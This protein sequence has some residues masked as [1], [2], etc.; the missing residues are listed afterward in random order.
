MNPTISDKEYPVVETLMKPDSLFEKRLERESREN[1]ELY[2]KINDEIQLYFKKKNEFRT[3][4]KWRMFILF[5]LNAFILIIARDLP[6]ILHQEQRM[7][8]K[9]RSAKEDPPSYYSII[10]Y[11]LIYWVPNMFLPLIFGFICDYAANDMISLKLLL[12]TMLVPVLLSQI[13]LIIKA[14]YESIIVSRFLF[15]FTG[16]TAFVMLISSLEVWF[17]KINQIS[18]ICYYIIC[19]SF[20]CGLSYLFLGILSEY[21]KGNNNDEDNFI[22]VESY[23]F[24]FLIVLLLIVDSFIYPQ[25]DMRSDKVFFDDVKNKFKDQYKLKINQ[26]YRTK[27]TYV[28]NSTITKSDPSSPPKN[29]SQPQPQ[30]K[31]DGIYLSS[32]CNTLT[33]KIFNFRVLMLSVIHA[34]LVGCFFVFQDSVIYFL[35]YNYDDNDHKEDYDNLENSPYFKPETFRNIG[36]INFGIQMVKIIITFCFIPRFLKETGNRNLLLTLSVI[37][38]TFA[39]A[40]LSIYFES[41]IDVMYNSDFTFFNLNDTLNGFV[42]VIA[43]CAISVGNCFQHTS[44]FACIPV[45]VE[46]KYYI[47]AFGFFSCIQAIVAVIFHSIINSAIINHV[48]DDPTHKRYK[49]IMFQDI[50][51]VLGILIIFLIIDLMLVIVLE[52][53]DQ[54]KGRKLYKTIPIKANLERKSLQKLIFQPKASMIDTSEE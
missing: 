10:K 6:F 16:E 9:Q 22:E 4:L 54:R 18:Y 36:F 45:L 30:T 26:K 17:K 51:P 21:Y 53:Y 2:D 37:A 34:I 27:Q 41:V 15:S 3:I 20:G 1:K 38:Y 12:I 19:T 14:K 13:I 5:C 11:E 40:L 32:F 46:D 49:Y 35:F 39:F 25:D 47:T 29:Y 33:T 23:I 42:T 44:F 52:S 28:G 8:R 24:L 43:L 50:K 31:E 7:T 48:E